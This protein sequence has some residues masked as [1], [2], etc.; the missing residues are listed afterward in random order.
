MW[1]RI[2]DDRG[3]V[4]PTAVA[5][6]QVHIVVV[7]GK[8]PKG[9]PETAERVYRDL[10]AGGVEALLDDR[11]ERAGVKFNDADLIGAPI[12]V[13]VGARGLEKG[14]VEVKRRTEERVVDVPTGD[15]VAHV[16][17]E[18]E[19]MQHQAQP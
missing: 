17:G 2:T 5:P 11:D 7:K 18:I 4:W 3:I 15:L 6:F 12:R 16:R 8:A 9:E 10:W 1:N 19:A 13:T 14:C